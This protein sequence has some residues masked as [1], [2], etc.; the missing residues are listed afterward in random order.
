MSDVSAVGAFFLAVFFLSLV[1][2]YVAIRRELLTPLSAGALCAVISSVSL[3]MFGVI[4][5]GID[6][7]LA[8]TGGLLVGLIFTGMMVTMASYFRNNQP[9]TLR[10]YEAMLKE[11]QNSDQ[12]Q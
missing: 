3:V 6:D 2:F 1:G 5:D 7:G 12:Q 9:E 8:L 10:A 4:D 11:R